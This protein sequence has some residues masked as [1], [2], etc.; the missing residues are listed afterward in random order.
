M[1]QKPQVCQP[2]G[3]WIF[4]KGHEEAPEIR[5]LRGFYRLTLL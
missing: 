3:F 2:W 1:I 5:V 4:Y